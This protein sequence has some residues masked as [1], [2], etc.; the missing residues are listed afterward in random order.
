MRKNRLIYSALLA[1]TGLA[2]LVASPVYARH[3]EGNILTNRIPEPAAY[4]VF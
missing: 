3:G 2:S 1:F 4:R